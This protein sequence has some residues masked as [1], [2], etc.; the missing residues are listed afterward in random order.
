MSD[1]KTDY[2]AR[3]Y[4]SYDSAQAEPH[5]ILGWY[6]TWGLS[7]VANVPP[8]SSMIPVS[9]SDWADIKFRAI[10]G[11]AVQ[12]GK[13]IDYTPPVPKPSSIS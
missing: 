13:I 9:A 5:P 7:T 12:G 4:V 10:S 8:A 11:K 6:D 3:F 1:V 2:P